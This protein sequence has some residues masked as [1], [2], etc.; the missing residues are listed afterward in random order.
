MLYINPSGATCIQRVLHVAKGCYMYPKVCL[1]ECVCV[2]KK[3]V[4]ADSNG[5]NVDLFAM[6]IYK[7]IYHGSITVSLLP[8]MLSKDL[9]RIL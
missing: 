4:L 8:R 6:D 1:Y 9:F 2:C 5:Y 7:V 3:G